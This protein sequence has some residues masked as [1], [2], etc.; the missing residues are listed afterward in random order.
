MQLA[1]R[2]NNETKK[3]AAYQE[4]NDAFTYSL[5][6]ENCSDDDP[7]K[8]EKLSAFYE[9]LMFHLFSTKSN[10]L[11]SGKLLA[12]SLKVNILIQALCKI[13]KN[14]SDVDSDIYD[15]EDEGYDLFIASNLILQ[16]L[17]KKKYRTIFKDVKVDKKGVRK[18]IQTLLS[19]NDQ[20]LPATKMERLVVCACEILS[21]DSESSTSSSEK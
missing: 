7:T 11:L 12:A 18:L 20:E 13:K 10:S 8:L 14:E 21:S 4:I 19:S 2:V 15:D 16:E 5:N 1:K 9:K 3:N 6:L 17:S